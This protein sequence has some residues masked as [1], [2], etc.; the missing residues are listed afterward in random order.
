MNAALPQFR[1]AL[2]NAG[3]MMK[4]K[5]CWETFRTQILLAKFVWV[6]RCPRKRTPKPRSLEMIFP[7]LS[8][9]N[10]C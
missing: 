9:F 1:Q 6:A 8:A 4:A 5:R 2:Q 3:S 7:S 10:L